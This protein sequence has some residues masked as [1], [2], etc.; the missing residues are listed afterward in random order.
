MTGNIPSS[1]KGNTG[2]NILME[3]VEYDVD[4]LPDLYFSKVAVRI[5]DKIYH[6]KSGVL[7]SSNFVEL[8]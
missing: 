4:G 3:D 6:G 1:Y 7:P 2:K 5:F 8:I